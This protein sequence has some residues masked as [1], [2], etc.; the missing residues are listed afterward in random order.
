[1]IVNIPRYVLKKYLKLE[2]DRSYAD[3]L[4]HRVKVNTLY[5]LDKEAYDHEQNPFYKHRFKTE[6]VPLFDGD[7]GRRRNPDFRPVPVIA[8]G[9][10]LFHSEE[11]GT[12]VNLPE[13]TRIADVRPSR[14]VRDRSPRSIY[15]R[16]D[17]P[18]RPEYHRSRQDKKVGR[19][20]RRALRF[21]NRTYGRYSEIA[22]IAEAF[23]YNN[24]I[25]QILTALAI[26]EAVDYA[27]GRRARFLRDEIY[28]K[29][30]Y[31]LPVG[32]DF[33]KSRWSN[34]ASYR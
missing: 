12:D 27:Y 25:P 33:I 31:K 3:K 8:P 21:V 28:S 19:L 2:T 29:D 9:T 15:L 32:I 18:N 17:N 26:N 34:V 11:R 30:W 1:M 13:S 22:E 5:D 23:Q 14:S 16:P 4:L 24:E 6:V 7:A 20:Y 10:F